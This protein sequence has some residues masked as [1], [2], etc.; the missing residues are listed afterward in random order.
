[1][2]CLS[3]K[4][5]PRPEPQPAEPLDEVAEEDM[6]S[7]LAV[8]RAETAHVRRAMGHEGV[9]EEEYMESWAALSREFIYLPKRQRYDRSISATNTDRVESMQARNTEPAPLPVPLHLL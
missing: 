3:Q 2:C 7:A 9:S 1:M 8:L 4:K 6:A 5:R